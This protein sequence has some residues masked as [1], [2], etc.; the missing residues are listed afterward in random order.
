M[1]LG[2]AGLFGGV[3]VAFFLAGLGLVWAA[4]PEPEEVPVFRPAGVPA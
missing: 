3:G 4:R 1:G 2:L